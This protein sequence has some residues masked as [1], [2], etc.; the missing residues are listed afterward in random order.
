[1]FP[2]NEKV[3]TEYTIQSVDYAHRSVCALHR[4]D[5]G[6]DKHM[7]RFLPLDFLCFW[8]APGTRMGWAND[9]FPL[10]TYATFQKFFSL[11]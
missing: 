3:Y 7:T 5:D 9:V 4:H 6:I 1:M 11:P 2:F 10:D 8:H